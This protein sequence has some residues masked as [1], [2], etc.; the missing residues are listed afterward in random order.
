MFLE[1]NKTSE[2]K[3]Q[4]NNKCEVLLQLAFSLAQFAI[5]ITKALLYADT[6]AASVILWRHFPRPELISPA[7]EFCGSTTCDSAKT[8][9]M[10]A[11]GSADSIQRLSQTLHRLRHTAPVLLEF[12]NS[13]RWRET[14]QFTWVTALHSDSSPVSKHLSRFRHRTSYHPCN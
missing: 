10:S 12:I 5:A 6:F 1:V 11:V 9:C 14:H 13:C 3:I 2:Q 7:A 8:L 4:V